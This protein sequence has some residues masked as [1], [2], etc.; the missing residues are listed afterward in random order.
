MKTALHKSRLLHSSILS[1]SKIRLRT[2]PSAELVKQ[3]K[4]QLIIIIHSEIHHPVNT[5]SYANLLTEYVLCM[6]SRYTTVCSV[7]LSRS[8]TISQ[9]NKT[10]RLAV[11]NQRNGSF[12][13][14]THPHSTNAR[15]SNIY[16][17]STSLVLL[18]LSTYT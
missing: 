9:T 18:F 2:F 11:Q 3:F 10:K 12:S 14:T 4:K 8:A 16:C 13:G 1:T 6:Q 7:T 15:I 5:L 17:T